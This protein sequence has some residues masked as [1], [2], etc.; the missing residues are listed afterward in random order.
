[1]VGHC[2]QSCW[3]VNLIPTLDDAFFLHVFTIVGNICQ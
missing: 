2:V 3:A 1:M